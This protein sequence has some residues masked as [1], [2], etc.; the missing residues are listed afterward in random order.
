MPM[1]V[2]TIFV[3]AGSVG[4]IG[5]V[6]EWRAARR[7]EREAVTVEAAVVDKSVE[8]ANRDDN[9]VTRYLVTYRFTPSAGGAV[10]Q[11][12]AIAVER[13]E[14]LAA[15]NA[16]TVRYLPDE[17]STARTQ[18]ATP[19]WA[20]PLVAAVT[21]A[22]AVLGA[23]I[24]WPWWRRTLVL[25]RVHRS[26]VSAQASVIE[27]APTGTVV[28]RVPQWRL[29]YEFRDQRGE[30]HE[31]TSDYLHPHDAAEW[32]AGDR[33]AIR[34]DRNRPVDSVWLGRV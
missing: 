24:A 4:S 19:A 7:F 2:G 6:G 10:E 25:V 31:G 21:A 29:K 17:P 32:R 3:V 11:T 34:Y 12:E 8:R 23:L 15:G 22:F 20:P 28:N 9:P 14:E 5:S 16:V 18:S 13:W 27:V 33:G 1:W 30:R 26:G